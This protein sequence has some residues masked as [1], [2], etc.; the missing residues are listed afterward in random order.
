MTET[1]LQTQH[2]L[3]M[4]MRLAYFW[5]VMMLGI[6]PCMLLFVPAFCVVLS[7]VYELLGVY[8]Y[9][10]LLESLYFGVLGMFALLGTYAAVNSLYCVCWEKTLP[11][12]T[13]VFGFFGVIAAVSAILENSVKLGLLRVISA[14]PIVAYFITLH[15]NYMLKKY[16]NRESAHV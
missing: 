2:G 9:D 7:F 11:R 4:W 5:S 6:V 10:S 13:V 12:R 1:A 16:M 14:P 3:P 8:K 15:Y